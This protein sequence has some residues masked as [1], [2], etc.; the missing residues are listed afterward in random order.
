M[1]VTRVGA[2]TRAERGALVTLC[3]AVNALGHAMPPMYI[4]PSLRYHE[5]LVDGGP[6]G[7]VGASQKSGWM[8]ADNFLLFLQHFAKHSKSTVAS[9]V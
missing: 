3:C 1:G 2:I 9:P 5:R 7:C 8:T 4:F 6:P